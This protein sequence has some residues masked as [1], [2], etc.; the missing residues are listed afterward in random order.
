[1]SNNEQVITIKYGAKL[2]TLKSYLIGLFLSLLLTFTAFICVGDHLL[3][4]KALFILITALAV[5]QLFTQV[6]CFLRLNM[7]DEGRWNSLAFVFTF[8]VV[9]VLVGGSLWIMYNLNYNMM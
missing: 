1:M 7:S 6:I 3:P 5:A 2:K 4:D 8:I 9:F